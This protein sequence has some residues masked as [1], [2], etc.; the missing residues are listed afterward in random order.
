VTPY[1]DKA[2]KKG[3]DVVGISPTRL[4]LVIAGVTS[5][6]PKDDLQKLKGSLDEIKVS[7]RS[8]LS[9]YGDDLCSRMCSFRGE[10]QGRGPTTSAAH[11]VQDKAPD[12]DMGP[13]PLESELLIWGKSC[14]QRLLSGWVLS[15]D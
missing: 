9:R 4:K 3:V 14:S 1:V 5:G 13:S 2:G 15:R 8:L 10:K 11:T 7:M 12:R 6:V